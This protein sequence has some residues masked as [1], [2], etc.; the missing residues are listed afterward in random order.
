MKAIL[1]LDPW[2]KPG[3]TALGKTVN[4]SYKTRYLHSINYAD[5][6]AGDAAMYQCSSSLARTRDLMPA[7]STKLESKD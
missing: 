6:N 5:S 3:M 1:L 2:S 7:T 4:K